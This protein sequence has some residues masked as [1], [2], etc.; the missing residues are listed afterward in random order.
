MRGC[1]QQHIATSNEH[2]PE[3]GVQLDDKWPHKHHVVCVRPIQ[4]KLRP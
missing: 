4:Q 1:Y 3:G 2:H